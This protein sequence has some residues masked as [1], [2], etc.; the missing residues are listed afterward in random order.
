MIIFFNIESDGK[1]KP[2]YRGMDYTVEKYTHWFLD[3]VLIKHIY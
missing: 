2:K 3:D 1:E